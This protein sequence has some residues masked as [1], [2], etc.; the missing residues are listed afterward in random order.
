MMNSILIVDDIADNL[1]VLSGTLSQKGY[2][3]RC[4]KNGATAL[5]VANKVIPDLILLDIKM[6]GMNGYEVCQKLKADEQTKDIPII[7]L[8][9]LDDVLDKVKAFE[10]GGIDYITKPFQ[11]EEVLVRVKTH[12]ALQSAKAKVYQLN[13]T[14]LQKMQSIKK[15]SVRL[16]MMNQKLQ[17]EIKDR[18]KAE[19]QLIH[20]ALHDGLTGLPNR[21]LLMERINFAIQH[22]KR[23]PNY[24][25]ALLFIDLDKFKIV[26]DSMG[27][28]I[29]DK[30]LIAIAELLQE[31]LRD[32]DTVA[33]LGGDEFAILLNDLHDIT[34]ATEVGEIVYSSVSI[35]R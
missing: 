24:L 10:V 20:D 17:Q 28:L 22:A 26:N 12:L 8:S 11:V 34:D 13:L 27:H 3:I 33:R 35:Y 30:L 9:A 2:K 19:S 29:G 16:E 15:H 7:F 18:Q 4:A 25:F 23:N 5:K 14:L 1:R 32:S 6:P 21:T 31:D